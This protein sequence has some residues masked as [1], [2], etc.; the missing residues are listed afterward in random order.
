VQ[1]TIAQ[2]NAA[3]TDTDLVPTTRN[4]TTTAPLVGGGPL[5]GDLALAISDYTVSARGAVPSPGGVSSGRFL[6][7]DGTWAPPPSATSGAGGVFPFTYN[8]ATVEPPIGNQLRANAILT[9]ATKLWV[10]ESTVDGLDV[11]IGLTRIKSGMQVYVQNFSN[12]AQYVLYNVTADSVDKG[13]YWELTVAVNTSSG[14]IPGGKV[15]FQSLTP[16]VTGI[17]TGGN[18]GQVL[19]KTTNADYAVA[20]AAPTMP[21]VTL[22]QLNT[23]ITDAD[24][25]EAQNGLVAVWIGTTAQYNAIATKNPNT[26]YAVS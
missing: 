25:P 26:L 19:T 14:T 23:G 1:G 20:W 22:A 8:T 12:S 4:V 7:D 3:V 13:A 5:S 21:P 18:T 10:S 9:L 17:P 24:V 16:V 11:T 2:F 6:K 15:A